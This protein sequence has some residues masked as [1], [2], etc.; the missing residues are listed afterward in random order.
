MPGRIRKAA[1]Q[2]EA[3]ATQITDQSSQMLISHLPVQL[4]SFRIVV[5]EA[6]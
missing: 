2:R 1:A 5:T 4:P 6:T 3:E